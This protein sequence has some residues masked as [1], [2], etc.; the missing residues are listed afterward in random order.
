MFAVTVAL[1]IASILAVYW[2]ALIAMGMGRDL[3]SDIFRKV[4]AFSQV[5]VNA[6]GPA[7]LI[8]RNTNDVQQVQMVVFMALTMILSAPILIIGGIIMAIRQDVPLSG[9]LVVVLPIMVAFIGV[10]MARAI[11][12]FRAMQTKLDRTAQVMREVCRA[13]GSSGPSFGPGT[14]KSGSTW[15]TGT[16]LT[17]SSASTAFSPSPSRQ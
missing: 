6:F 13:F 5:E 12:L 4:Q 7:T 1:G 16:C 8:T 15:R 11:P 3:R 14:R 10:V 17:P 9:L 2:G